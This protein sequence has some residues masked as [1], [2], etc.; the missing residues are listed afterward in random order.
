LRRLHWYQVEEDAGSYTGDPNSSGEKRGAWARAGLV[1]MGR[2]EGDITDRQKITWNSIW[3]VG[4][5][6]HLNAL[7]VVMK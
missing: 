1:E 3:I 7:S 6:G 4:K 2:K 5:R